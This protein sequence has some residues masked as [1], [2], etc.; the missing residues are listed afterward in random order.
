MLLENL[1][2]HLAEEKPETDPSFTKNLA[3]LGDVYVND[4]FGSAHR[5]H[6]ST[7]FLANEF[8]GKAA[9]GF[10]MEKEMAYI[11]GLLS[12]PEHPFFAMVGGA[13][14]GSKIG[15]LVAL[16]KKVDGFFIGGGM[17]Y[18]FFKAQ[19][20]SIG[21]SIFDEVNL[22]VAKRFLKH[23]EE[24]NVTVHLPEDIVIADQFDNEAKKKSSLHKRRHPGWLAGTRH[25]PQNYCKVVS[26]S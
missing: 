1:R 21:D 4:A 11:G 3:K 7:Y 22:S 10:L 23:C 26:T 6:A 16:S 9:S 20:I 2:F 15:A 5:K 18:T 8:P 19:G 24:Q 25:R 13:K 12:N 14:I 17:A